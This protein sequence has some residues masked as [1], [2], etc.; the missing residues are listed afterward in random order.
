MGAKRVQYQIVGRYMSGK[1]VTAYHLQS[2]DTGKAG[3][4]TR[5]QVAFL[6]G[7]DQ[8][9]NCTGQLYQD[10]LILRGNGMSLDDLP[11]QYDD[12]DTRNAEKLGKI[13]RGTSLPEAMEQFLIVGTIKSGRNTVGYVIQNAGCGIKKIKRQQVI[14]L[15]QQGK[16]GNAR[17][18][19]YNGKPLLRGYNCNLDDLPCENIEGE[20][21]QKIS[22]D[23]SHSINNNEVKSV[24]QKKNAN[25]YP[26]YVN[27]AVK[28][29]EYIAPRLGLEKYDEEHF[30]T[31]LAADA[32]DGTD[33]Y[34]LNIVCKKHPKNIVYL[35][36]DRGNITVHVDCY[37]EYTGLYRTHEKTITGNS[38]ESVKRALEWL[39]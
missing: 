2:I 19:M 3:K 26:D 25:E 24:A 18:Q 28:V 38:V 21:V 9:T 17:V 37:N 23:V 14:E 29:F 30:I 35:I 27:D 34:F 36:F 11:V 13:R 8:V 1:E 31:P 4:Y 5:E 33:G 10:K 12:G 16:I 7:R 32:D 39:T 15:A 6:V 22:R 20:T